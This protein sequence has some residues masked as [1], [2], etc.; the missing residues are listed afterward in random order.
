MLIKCTGELSQPNRSG[1]WSFWGKKLNLR[2][3]KW[4]K[5]FIPA[6]FSS[7]LRGIA[8]R[9][10]PIPGL[11]PAAL[12][13]LSVALICTMDSLCAWLRKMRGPS[14]LRACS[15]FAWSS[16]VIVGQANR[17]PDCKGARLYYILYLMQNTF[18][19]GPFQLNKCISIPFAN[20]SL[21]KSCHVVK[22]T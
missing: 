12:A 21:V 4:L 6:P 7:P 14:E 15:T 20:Y 17:Y 8:A 22:L 1:K 2:C 10:V 9:Y 3:Q 16:G 13:M 18:W 11:A 19:S 5:L